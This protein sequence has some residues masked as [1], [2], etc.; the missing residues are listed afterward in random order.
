M[1]TA[2]FTVSVTGTPPFGYRWRRGA[3]TVVPFELGTPMLVLSNVTLADAG[4]YNV[5]VTNVINLSPGVVSSSA[6]LTVLAGPGSDCV[7]AMRSANSAS[8]SQRRC[9]TY[10]RRK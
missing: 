2:I 6:R 4:N 8:V 3:G 7:R 9:S 5:V 10:S 1:Q